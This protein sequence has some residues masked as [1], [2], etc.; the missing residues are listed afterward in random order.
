MELKKIILGEVT[1]IQ[2]DKCH[3]FSVSEACG[4][5]SSDLS[6]ILQYQHKP[7]IKGD[8]AGTG[9]CA[10]KSWGRGQQTSNDLTGERGKRE[11]ADMCKGGEK[12]RAK[13]R[14]R[15]LKKKKKPRTHVSLCVNIIYS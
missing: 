2:K 12:Y 3:L 15:N 6:H 14:K 1:Q 9:G 8:T 7:G 11:E 5:K 13:E 4:T 10:G